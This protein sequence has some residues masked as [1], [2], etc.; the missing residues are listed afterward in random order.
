MFDDIL[1]SQCKLV[2]LGVGV[3][4]GIIAIFAATGKV[5]IFAALLLG[6][7]MGV[8]SRVFP[9]SHGRFEGTL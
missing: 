9:Q 1:K 6:L 8:F 4:A 2:C 5:G 7:A 3:V